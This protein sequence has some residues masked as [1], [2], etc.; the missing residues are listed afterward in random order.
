M[1]ACT[2]AC[3]RAEACTGIQGALCTAPWV[4]S[5]MW[6]CSV[7]DGVG[8]HK[9]MPCTCRVAPSVCSVGGI[10][11]PWC[12]GRCRSCVCTEPCDFP[13]AACVF[14]FV[15]G[16]ACVRLNGMSSG[17]V[18]RETESRREAARGNARREDESTYV[19]RVV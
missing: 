11:D 18:R 15:V 13:Q 4:A 16:V 17:T 1:E 2:K 9:A 3:R 5:S 8:A 10:W 12:Y 7:G 14:A 6:M 19:L